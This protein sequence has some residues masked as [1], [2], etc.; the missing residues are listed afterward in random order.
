MIVGC[1]G[2]YIRFPLYSVCIFGRGAEPNDQSLVLQIE[3]IGTLEHAIR[4]A[5]EAFK[6]NEARV[7]FELAEVNYE[8]RM[9]LENS[10]CEIPKEK[11]EKYITLKSK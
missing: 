4:K 9:I 5:E 3:H 8:V 1:A 2:R 10:S 11:Y 6:A 7:D